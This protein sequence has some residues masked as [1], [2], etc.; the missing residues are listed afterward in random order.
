GKVLLSTWL[1]PVRA[2][3]P[4]LVLFTSGAGFTDFENGTGR[5]ERTLGDAELK[6]PIGPEAYRIERSLEYVKVAGDGTVP[7]LSAARGRG[8]AKDMNAPNAVVLPII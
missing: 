3:P 2:P 8:S 7:L 5:Q 1:T 6:F 4:D